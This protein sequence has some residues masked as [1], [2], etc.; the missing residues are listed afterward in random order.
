MDKIYFSKVKPNAI[1]PSKR[2]EDGC[3]DLYACFDGDELILHPNKPTLIDTGIA[4]AFSSKYRFNCKRERG[5]TGIIAMNILSGQIDSGYRGSWFI[6]IINILNKPIV[7]SKLVD[8]T[9]DRDDYIV[10]PASKGICQ[11]A[12][13]FVPE[14]EIE[15]ISYDE[16]LK[17]ESK[18]GMGKIGS[19]GK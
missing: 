19:S 8:K 1:I 16:L 9:E 4:S 18:R 17:I 11:T 2:D 12:L 10:Y 5:S 6:N 13:E 3:Y 14:V 15:E 7:I